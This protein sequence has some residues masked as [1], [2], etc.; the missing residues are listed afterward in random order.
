[1]PLPIG[2]ESL[3]IEVGDNPGVSTWILVGIYAFS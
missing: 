3:G 2:S 1:M